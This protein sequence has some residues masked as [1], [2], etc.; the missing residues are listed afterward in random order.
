MNELKKI[1]IIIAIISSSF[2]LFGCKS[3]TQKVDYSSDEEIFLNA[4]KLFEEKEYKESQ[5]LLD[6]LSIQYPASKYADD[7]QYYLAEINFANEEYILAAFNYNRLLKNFSA[8]EYA[9]SAM[10]KAALSYFEL[11]PSY[12]RDQR[13]TREAIKAFRDFQ[14]TYPNDS[15]SIEASNK[16]M[17]LREKLANR[18]FFTAELYKKLDSPISSIIYYDE[19]INNYS[20]TKFFEPAFFGKIQT[21]FEI[22]K[23]E[24]IKSLIPIYKSTFPSG[25]FIAN[26]LEIE[27]SIKS[28]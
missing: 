3:A 13:Y 14:M 2:Y 26:V 25:K 18:E 12:D 16:I 24:Q 10:Y 7:A 5:S 4:K 1:L 21:L 11:S 22:G 28:N 20:D 6:L 8:S 17:Q 23:Y 19:V 9:K 15:L 27:K